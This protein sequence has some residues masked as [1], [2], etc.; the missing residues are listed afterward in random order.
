MVGILKE[1][2][3]IIK[4]KNLVSPFAPDRMLHDAGSVFQT[5]DERLNI[6][7]IFQLKK[8][9]Q[10]PQ[11]ALII[12]NWSNNYCWICCSVVSIQTTEA[13]SEARGVPFHGRTPVK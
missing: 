4:I 6:N 12:I 8:H 11:F 13:R 9:T 2:V 10:T 7:N 3:T 1:Y 5:R